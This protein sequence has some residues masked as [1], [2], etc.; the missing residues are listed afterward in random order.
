MIREAALAVLALL[1]GAPA[2]APPVDYADP[3]SLVAVAGTRRIALVCA[4]RG[5]PTVVLTAGAGAPASS[6]RLVQPEIA[7]RTR[8]CA[9]DRA[10]FGRSDASPARQTADET[11]RDLA[12]ALAS[13]KVT[14]PLVLV[15][16]SIG[17]Y[18]TLLLADRLGPRL[19]GMV[20]VD[21]SL[22]DMFRVTGDDPARLM[23]PIAAPFRAC[24]A[25]LRAGTPPP[26]GSFV[27][28]G[29][30]AKLD[31]AVSFLDSA[32]ESARLV[33][34]PD[35]TYGAIPLIVLTAG[36]RRTLA[37]AWDIGHDQLAALSSRGVNRY[38]KDSGHMMHRERPDAIIAAVGDVLS[39]VSLSSHTT[40]R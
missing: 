25:A 17:A 33:V 26:A 6:W 10:G 3:A 36:P 1:Q 4:G 37:S 32:G 13:A 16:H 34:A 2:P 35:R 5:A 21:P 28:A 23:G 29:P 14:G 15:G 11:A 39:A 7:R 18:E 27:C 22:P 24:A 20:L 31:T 12:R 8:T 19:A 9:W 40:T 38:V 30:V